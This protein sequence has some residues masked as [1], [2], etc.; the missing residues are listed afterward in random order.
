MIT[1]EEFIAAWNKPVGNGQLINMVTNDFIDHKNV[2][3]A[4]KQHWWLRQRD[5]N[6]CRDLFLKNLLLL[7]YYEESLQELNKVCRQTYLQQSFLIKTLIKLRSKLKKNVINSSHISNL[8][9]S[10]YVGQL[11]PI[12]KF[13]DNNIDK[14][15][16]ELDLLLNS[17][18]P[19]GFLEQ[20]YEIDE[21][22]R[23]KSTYNIKYYYK[24][25][26]LGEQAKKDLKKIKY[27]K[28]TNGNA[29][30]SCVESA[31]SHACANLMREAENNLRVSI[32]GKQIGEGWISETE[33]F[34]RVK[35]H[36]K[37]LKVIH[38]GRPKFLGQ[39]HFD[40]WIPEIK[41]AIEYQGA[42]HNEPIEFFG[43]KEAFLNNKKRDELK[44]KQRV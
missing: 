3:Y 31:I 7:G 34:Y 18:F 22:G 15:Y 42:K 24:Y 28:A 40:I 37:N 6:D 25:Y 1:K 29:P 9:N 41:V 27:R 36:F 43:G 23:I 14:L 13:G 8:R 39:Q 11:R 16:K 19:K 20:F 12:T 2:D 32:G 44:R 33:L 21:N 30:K 35:E 26:Q 10:V 17:N 4:R 5:P 38:H